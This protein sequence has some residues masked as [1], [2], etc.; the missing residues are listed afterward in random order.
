M[1]LKTEFNCCY[2]ED[3]FIQNGNE[4]KELTVI[5]TLGEYRNL[6]EERTRNEKTIENLEEELKKAK[7]SLSMFA[8]LMLIKSPEFIDKVCDAFREVLPKN[9]DETGEEVDEQ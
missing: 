8:K 3:N 7:E 1:S 6:I 9:E 5:I 2:N 4:M